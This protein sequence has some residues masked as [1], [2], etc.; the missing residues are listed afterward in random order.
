MTP[1]N[2]SISEEQLEIL[3]QQY[4]NVGKNSHVGNLAVEIA[5]LFLLS[6]NPNTTFL[7]TRGID[8]TANIDGNIENFEIKG[9]SSNDISWDKLKVSS[10]FC[11]DNLVNG[12]KIIRVTNIGQ[13]NMTIYYLTHDEDYT[14]A[15]ELRWTIR[16]VRNN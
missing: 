1:Y 13:I 3:L 7:T 6:L 11:H 14:L 5:K 16:K 8:L 12:M 15:P 10:Q 4:S 9:T 2:F